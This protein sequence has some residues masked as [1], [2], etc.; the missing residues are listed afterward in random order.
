MLNKKVQQVSITLFLSLLSTLYFL[1]PNAEAGADTAADFLKLGVGA[2]ASAMG[3]AFCG[4]ADGVESIYFN[5][6]GLAYLTKKEVWAMYG[7]KRE[8]TS[9]TF[10]GYAQPIEEWEGDGVMGISIIHQDLGKIETRN[11]ANAPTGDISPSEFA[12]I[13]SY[14][15]LYYENVS[16]G[17]SLK[18]IQRN[19]KEMK[20]KGF[21]IDFGVL[22]KTQIPNLTLG[23]CIENLGSK[24][25]GDELPLNLRTGLAYQPMNNLLLSLDLNKHFYNSKLA[26]N[27]GIE[28]TYNILAIRLGYLDKGR[29]VDGLTYGFGINYKVYQLDFANVS[30]GEMDGAEDMNRIS[31]SVSW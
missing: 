15:K 25:K 8:D 14:S 13:L 29:K 22:C 11:K 6:A 31:L 12:L 20:G 9:R 23:A 2:R 24:I 4:V 18:Y 7:D 19:L 1:L 30:S 17:G 3:E 5:P 21:G 27:A 10:L 26:I 16:L 28:Y